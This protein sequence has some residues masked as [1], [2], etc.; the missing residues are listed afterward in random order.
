MLQGTKWTCV[1]TRQRPLKVAIASHCFPLCSSPSFDTHTQMR[2]VCT[3]GSLPK[4]CSAISEGYPH[5]LTSG[6]TA[7]RA[8][9]SVKKTRRTIAGRTLLLKRRMHRRIAHH[10]TR[11]ELHSNSAVHD[12]SGAPYVRC[13]RLTGSKVHH[14]AYHLALG[15]HVLLPAPTS[16]PVQ[17]PQANWPPALVVS[18][19][20]ELQPWP[21]W[22]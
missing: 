4:E 3:R 17:K 15:P 11:M 8:M 7:H 16:L 2:T 19:R 5:P 10:C 20:D 22:K 14:S 6:C 12:L 18:G 21:G 13:T 1:E 9:R